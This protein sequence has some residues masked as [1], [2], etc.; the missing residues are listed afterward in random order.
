MTRLSR[1]QQMTLWAVACGSGGSGSN[2]RTLESLRTR[3]LIRGMEGHV[4]G[5]RGWQWKT[6]PEGE[7]AVDAMRAR[8]GVSG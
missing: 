8:W 2:P 3:G 5:R 6:T 1:V 4:D 7:V